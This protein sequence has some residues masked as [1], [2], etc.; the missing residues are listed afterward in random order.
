MEKKTHCPQGHPYL[1]RNL[2]INRRGSYLCRIC[3][4]AAQRRWRT[5]YP[6]RAKQSTKRW[7]ERNMD[8]WRARC[9]ES[10]IRK[11]YGITIEDRERIRRK[12]GGKCAI[13]RRV[14][15]NGGLVVDHDHKTG[16]VRGLLCNH[17][18]LTLGKFEDNPAWF[19]KLAEYLER[20]QIAHAV[21]P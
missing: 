20:H 21:P 13:C 11:R 5:Q 2:I 19:R 14:S 12:Q 8:R 4:T 3:Q 1:G 6:E 10:K 15:G 16:K 7:Q 18:N 17:C 9:N